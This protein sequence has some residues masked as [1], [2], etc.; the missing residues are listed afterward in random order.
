MARVKDSYRNMGG[1]EKAAVFMLSL[2]TEHSTQLFS[3][4][5]DGRARNYTGFR[6]FWG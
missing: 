1:Q 5:D 4:M 3:M 2:D 6:L